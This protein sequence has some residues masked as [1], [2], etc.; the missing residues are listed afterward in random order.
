MIFVKKILILFVFIPV[1]ATGQNL[2]LSDRNI[3]IQKGIIYKKEFSLEAK[4]HTLGFAFGYNRGIISKYYLTKYYH[5]DIGY[6]KSIKEKR[7]NLVITG[8]TIYNSY[9]YGKRNYFLPVRLGM[10]L[11]KYL[12]E[13]EAY[14]GVSVGY[15]LE[16]GLTLGV[17]KPYFLVVRTKNDDNEVFYKT[18]KYTEENR[19]LFI[20]ENLIFDR[21]SFFKGFDQLSMLPGIHINAALHYAIKAFEKSVFAFETGI[22]I[23]AF[24]K[25]VPVMVETKNFK[26]KSLFINVYI[27]VQIGKRWN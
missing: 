10:G 26:N 7:N 15:S 8:I 20:D 13:K 12:S 9:S 2:N 21:S 27:N 1:F 4:L 3:L 16:G 23:D 14:H 19:D 5:F 22:M 6:L 18:I 25:K 24:I 17:L 11:K